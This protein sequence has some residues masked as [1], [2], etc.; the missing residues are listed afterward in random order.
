MHTY[1]GPKRDIM[2]GNSVLVTGGAGFIGST[3]VRTLIESFQE[4]IVLEKFTYA[5]DSRNLDDVN[6][7]IHLVEGDI[8]DKTDI[9]SL[10]EHVD[11][12]I[13]SAAESHVDRSID[14]GRPFVRTN[15]EGTYVAIDAL[16][17]ADIER[18]VHL[19]TDEVYGSIEEGAF[20]EDDPLN[21]SSPYSAS[22]AS[23]DMFIN[24]FWETYD[25]PITVVRPTNVYGP[26]QH[27]EKLIP[28]FTLRAIQGKPLP[29]Y[30]D[31]SNIRQW[32][33]VEDLAAILHEMLFSESNEVFN[34]AGSAHK[35]N[36]EVTQ[37]IIDLVGASRD[38]I[39]FIEDRKGH[40]H[41]YALSDDKLRQMIDL[42]DL[43][44]FEDG[45]ERTVNWYQQNVERY[46]R[47]SY[48]E[49]QN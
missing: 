1:N 12:V 33:F 24:A 13:N 27:P 10:Y 20:G 23:A 11:Y 31:G 39:E 35:T 2:S 41:R 49:R 32:L 5:G 42:G 40:D 36:L 45:L 8:R 37:A 28:K 25:V 22:K 7:D 21:P 4:V 46:T 34:V 15:V 44:S 30:G 6:D 38:Q 26:R 47:G 29:L 14:S 9:K 19:S 43:T 3:L 17:E 16:R 48:K 18:F